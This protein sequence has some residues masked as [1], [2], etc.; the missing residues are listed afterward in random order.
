MSNFKKNF[1]SFGKSLLFPISLLSFMAIF[2]GLAAALQ[3]PNIIKAIPFLGN[4]PLQIFL[5]LIRKVSG[6][7]FAQLPLLFAMAIPLGMVK[8][9]KEVAVFSAV[10][11][12]IAMLVG[13]SYILS[14][15]GLTPL[16]TTV[17]YLTA[18]KSM[19]QV[20]A[21]LKN[22]LFT[23]MLGIFVYNMNVIGGIIAGLMG[24]LIHNKFRKTELHPAL[25]F[26]SGKRFVPIISALIMV[27]VGMILAFVWPA[28]NAA[29]ISTGKLISE[30]GL[31]GVFLYGFTEK[32]INPTGLHHILNQTFRFTA[33]GGIETI[34]GNNLVGAMQIYLYQLDNNLQFST[35]ATQ[36]LAQ[37]K[38]LHMAFGMPAV[39]YAIYRKALPEKRDKVIKFFLAGLTAAILTGITEPIE[40]T[41]IFISPL[42]W[43]VNSVFAGLSFL[44]PAMFH[45]AIGNIQGGI[46][47]WFVFGVL[48][49]AQTKWVIYL[50]LGPIFFAMYYFS[51][52]FIIS[53]F[54]VMTIGRSKS[55]FEDSEEETGT[56]EALT[57]DDKISARNIVEGLGGLDNIVD[58]DNCISR[59]RVELKDGSKINK[60]LIKKT[61]PNGI[62]IPDP[63][64][65][66][67][68]YGGRVTK[69]RNMVDDYIYNLKSVK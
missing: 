44:V 42:L 34:D 54:N 30:A 24:V 39:V 2:L 8:R 48:Q 19:S 27:I 45:A 58:V 20:D 61:K 67:I 22:S 66:H 51:F 9:D 52:S 65:I 7:P 56:G 18:N 69:I 16:T 53:K 46:I 17:E 35:N 64:T 5:G 63:N 55:D 47:D 6:L 25:S 62:I 12:Y 49:G 10:V 50:F 14:V 11:G 38:I 68:V 40:F 31:F 43:I 37:G 57:G 36:Y 15:Q 60:D 32:I 13:I 59:L 3:N 41:F 29:I 23:N 26:Y 33:L 4:E 21:I 1:Q 28:I